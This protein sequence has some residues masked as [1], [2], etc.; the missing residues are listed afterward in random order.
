MLWHK[1]R[2]IL[3]SLLN[4]DLVELHV[5]LRQLFKTWDVVNGSLAVADG[6]EGNF[7]QPGD[8]LG[9]V[10]VHEDNHS[11]QDIVD[12]GLTDTTVAAGDD[13]QITFIDPLGGF[14]IPLSVVGYLSC[15]GG[16]VWGLGLAGTRQTFI[17][18][19]YKVK[20]MTVASKENSTYPR[21]TVISRRCLSKRYD[22]GL[23]SRI[24]PLGSHPRPVRQARK[25]PRTIHN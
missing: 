6:G 22:L 9:L 19:W 13:A 20:F 23:W 12:E 2:S 3:K 4:L 7:R 1:R 8:G 25:I 15:S 5:L 10:Q 16:H 17:K 11:Q 24:F 21:V 14:C 18:T